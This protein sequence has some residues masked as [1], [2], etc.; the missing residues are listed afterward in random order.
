[1]S[2]LKSGYFLG[3]CF[4]IVFHKRWLIAGHGV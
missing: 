3:V 1:M 4:V 2:V